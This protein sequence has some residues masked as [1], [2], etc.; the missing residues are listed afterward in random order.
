M[1]KKLMILGSLQEFVRLT[2]MAKDR[3]CTVIVSDGYPNGP[4]KKIADRAYDVDVRE[5][6][7][8]ARY[9]RQEHV[10]AIITSFSDLLFE[11][12]VKAADLA[13][14]KCYLKPEQLPYYRDKTVMK[15]LL[16]RLGIPTPRHVCLSRGFSDQQLEGLRFPVV[17]KPVDMYGSRGLYVLNSPQEVRRYFGK[18]SSFSRQ[19]KILVEEYNDG[20]EFNLM[21]W[22]LEGKVYILGIADR[23]KTSIGARDI[24]ISTRNIYP[25]RMISQVFE[26]AQKILESY[27]GATGQKNGALSMQFFWAPGRELEVCEIAGR[28][29]GYE[30]ELIEYSSGLSIEKLLLDYLFDE[31]ALKETLEHHSPF[32]KN[33]SAVLYFHGKPG[34]IANQQAAYDIAEWPEVMESQIFYKEGEP[35]VAHGPNPYMARYFITGKNRAYIDNV[36]KK[37]FDAMSIKDL[38]G[39]ELLYPNRMP[40]YPVL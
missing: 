20:Y 32:M 16:D 23:E 7:S 29:L 18:A 21:A 25:S 37:I 15:Q 33:H 1:K 13:G 19:K 34:M 28:F 35:V 24:P 10:D 3:G 26:P 22:V 27:I 5:A 11:N 36:T 6:P 12:M 14:L 40:S 8:L 38:Q 39:K 17:T 30:H 31:N 4:A 9:C 2:A